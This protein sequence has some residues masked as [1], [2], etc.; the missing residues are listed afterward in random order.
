MKANVTAEAQFF[1]IGK[2]VAS[3]RWFGALFSSLHYLSS[4]VGDRYDGRDECGGKCHGE[5][6]PKINS[7]AVE[8]GNPEIDIERKCG[9]HSGD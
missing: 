7:H 6:G 3:S 4:K 5:D 2:I 1:R 8:D 9:C